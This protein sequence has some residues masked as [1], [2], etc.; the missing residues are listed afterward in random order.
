MSVESLVQG[1]CVGD[2]PDNRDYRQPCPRD[3]WITHHVGQLRLS[4]SI[5]SSLFSSQ[6]LAEKTQSPAGH[7]VWWSM[8]AEAEIL[9]AL[10]ICSEKRGPTYMV[11]R[12]VLGEQGTISFFYSDSV[13]PFIRYPTGKTLSTTPSVLGDVQL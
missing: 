6:Q 13:M 8:M 5:T 9:L 10:P 1:Y 4:T 3:I 12:Q 7:V 11:L 2:L